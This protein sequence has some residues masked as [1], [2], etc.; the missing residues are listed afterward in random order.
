MRNILITGGAG[1][2]GSHVLNILN[3]EKDCHITILDNLSTGSES[4][5]PSGM[6]FI[7]GDICDK[8]LK[9]IFK[10][11]HFDVLIHLAAQTM[12][13]FSVEHPDIDADI[14]I[15]GLINIMEIA[16]GC[17]VKNV[18]FSSSAAVYGDNTNLPLKEEEE[19]LPT[20]FYGIT[21]MMTE[22]YL[23][24]Y[25]DI[26]NINATVLRFANVYGERQG[27]SGEGGVIFI[28][29]KKL[30]LGDDLVIFGDGK[31]TRDFVY[32][33]DVAKAIVNATQDQGYN[34]YNVSTNTEISINDLVTSLIKTAGKKV[35]V[36][37]EEPRTGDIFRSSLDNSKLVEKQKIKS[38]ISLE[39]GL[40]NTYK[41]FENL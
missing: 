11:K 31:Q 2:I 4:N 1:F 33:G 39:E 32:V 8:N 21:K 6:E 38:F 34:V 36:L 13:P 15:L 5:I 12:V 18:V 10:G 16:R 40:G 26:Y 30:A 22:H 17:G 3:K 24:V 25:A 23:R 27:A 29:C 14:N 7:K 28:F 35:N 41:Y 9:D 20:S 19:L 37:Y